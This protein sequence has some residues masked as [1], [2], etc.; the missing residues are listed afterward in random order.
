MKIMS[1]AVL[2]NKINKSLAAIDDIHLKSAYIIL[3][4]L[5][6]QQKLGKPG[7]PGNWLILKLS[8]VFI[9]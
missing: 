8:R 7:L 3:R 6:N 5:V 4:E 9:N 2:K 1:S